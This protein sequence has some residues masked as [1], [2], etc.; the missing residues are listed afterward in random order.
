MLQI[1]LPYPPQGFGI[2]S[3]SWQPRLKLAGTYDD[4]WLEQRWPD[5]PDDLD[6]AFWNGA[7]SDMQIPYLRGN[8][9][10]QL[11]NLMPTGVV[12]TI[13][14]SEGN[15]VASFELPGR[16]P[17]LFAQF[18]SGETSAVDFNIDTLIIDTE[19]RKLSLV[20][21]SIIPE[22]PVVWTLV[23]KINGK[24]DSNFLGT[25]E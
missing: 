21:R 6:F 25:A 11:T 23:A 8:E 7:H 14:D 5:I 12:P 17:H 3:K 20:Y 22:R 16:T 1:G 13:Q 15:S 19:N 9:T 10:I 4:A 24:V 18:G 2:I